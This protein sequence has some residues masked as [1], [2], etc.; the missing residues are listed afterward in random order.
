MTQIGLIRC[1]K[2]EDRC[3]LTGCFKC[4][5]NRKEGFAMYDDDCIPGGVFTCRCPGDNVAG[6][7][8]ILKSKGVDT[9]HFSTCTF[10]AKKDGKWVMEE[11]GFCAHI[12]DIIDRVH[13]AT[14]QTCIKGAAHLPENY[15]PQVWEKQA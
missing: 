15:T 7:A 14:G 5:V 6:L 12:D 9:I 4:L 11:G 8:K 13:Q 1:E 10:A 2:N 3:P